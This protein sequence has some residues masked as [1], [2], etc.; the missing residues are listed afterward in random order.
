MKLGVIT[1]QWS[2]WPELAERWRCLEE[3]GVE[4]IWVADHLGG[5]CLAPGAPWFEAWSCLTALAYETK[6]ARIGPL[7]S[8]MTYRN[9]GVLARQALTV[10]EISGGRLELGIGSGASAC[11]HE[12][13]QVPE[14]TPK[15]RAAAFVTWTERLVEMLAVERYH[16]K[17]DIPLTIAGRGQ[18]ILGPGRALRRP[19]EHVRRVRR[20]GRG[21]ASSRRRGT[22]RGS[23][24]CAPRRAARSSARSCSATTASSRR[25]RGARTRRSRT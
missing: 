13:T 16:P 7:V 19:L 25:R 3:L 14:W 18:T 6:R 8:P 23:T 11:D 2:P 22:T 1:L 17:H 5:E 4:T 10:A 15:E 9:P 24:S 20:L 12:V 21:G